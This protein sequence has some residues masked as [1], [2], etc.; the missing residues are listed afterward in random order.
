MASSVCLN[1]LLFKKQQTD[2]FD[3][4]LHTS[5]Q[6]QHAHGRTDERKY[7]LYGIY[8]IWALT[9]T[10]TTVRVNVFPLEILQLLLQTVTLDLGT[11]CVGTKAI[12]K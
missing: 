11:L 1:N 9:V 7:K 12:S 8:T 3:F 10:L 4:R 5:P 2:V 6:D